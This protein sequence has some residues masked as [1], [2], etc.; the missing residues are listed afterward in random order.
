[1]KSNRFDAET[2]DLIWSVAE[3]NDPKVREEFELRYPHLRAELATRKTMIAVL[4][5]SRPDAPQALRAK[6]YPPAKTKSAFVL[7]RPALVGAVL[8]GV[9]ALAFGSYQV[10]RMITANPKE[11]PGATVSK[12]PDAPLKPTPV[13]SN[14]PGTDM[15]EIVPPVDKRGTSERPTPPDPSS[16]LV[17]L[18]TTNLHVLE[19]LEAV[20]RQ[21]GVK[22]SVMPGVKDDLIDLGQAAALGPN[23]SLTVPEMLEVIQR[24]A[25]VKIIDNGSEGYIVLPGDKVSEQNQ[26]PSSRESGAPVVSSGG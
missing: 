17:T 18:S 11:Q 15:R 5:Q 6:F 23:M 22:F 24:G 9:F 12:V 21:A 4:K 13:Q 3:S 19:A 16:V 10:A 1:M 8:V 25:K 26:S 20:T 14:P 7:P 2:D